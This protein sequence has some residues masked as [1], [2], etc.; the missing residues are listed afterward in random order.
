M[1]INCSFTKYMNFVHILQYDSNK[2]ILNWRNPSTLMLFF[3][4]VSG[5]GGG[6][7]LHF[8]KGREQSIICPP[9]SFEWLLLDRYWIID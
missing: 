1:K 9:Y 4:G 6:V 7:S 3:M 8:L 2:N 5:G